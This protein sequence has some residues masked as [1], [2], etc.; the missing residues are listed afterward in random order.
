VQTQYILIIPHPDTK[1]ILVVEQDEVIT[2]PSAIRDE[3]CFWQAVDHVN[4]LAQSF[5]GATQEGS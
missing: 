3:A 2:L 4:V 5:T 1:Q